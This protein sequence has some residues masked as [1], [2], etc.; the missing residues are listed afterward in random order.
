MVAVFPSFVYF[1][2]LLLKDALSLFLFSL[3]GWAVIALRKKFDWKYVLA[4]LISLMCFLGIRSY[5]FYICIPLIAL[6]LLPLFGRSSITSVSFV[7]MLVILSIISWFLDVGL[8]GINFFQESK[9]LDIEYI[10][11]TRAE[12]NAGRGRMGLGGWGENYLSDVTNILA[13]IY[14]FFFSINPFSLNSIRQYFALPEMLIMMLAV[15]PFLRGLKVTWNH[16]RGAGIPLVILG[17]SVLVVYTS[18]T[19]NIGALYRWRMQAFPFLFPILA[20]GL[21]LSNGNLLTRLMNSV[22]R[23]V[24]DLG[25]S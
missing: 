17:L 22:T 24:N 19:T 14:Y 25:K 4:L 18:T 13:G 16:F 1:N 20:A 23:N 21:M 11:A 6:C 9:Y 7:I 10:N 5:L 15:L 8:L 3:L 12:M 2:S